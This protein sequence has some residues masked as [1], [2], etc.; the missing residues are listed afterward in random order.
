MPDFLS[1]TL[2]TPAARERE[3]LH[4]SSDSQPYDMRGTCNY[5][6]THTLKCRKTNQKTRGLVR[7]TELRF[8]ESMPAVA[9]EGSLLASPATF[10]EKNL[11]IYTGH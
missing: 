1:S 8:R 3:P 9:L 4:T 5:T 11:R 10:P 7:C 6:H 2:R